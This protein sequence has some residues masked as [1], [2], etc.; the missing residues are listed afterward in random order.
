MPSGSLP[1]AA[2][3]PA[4]GLGAD[5]LS[6]LGNLGY[7]RIEAQPAIERVLER[8]GDKASLDA[9]IRESLRELAR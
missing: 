9:V 2:I 7:R 8:L 3:A 5:A 6:A 4:Q 1:A